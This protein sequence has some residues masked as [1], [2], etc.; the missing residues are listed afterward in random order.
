MNTPLEFF[1]AEVTGRCQLQ[2]VHC[3]ADSGP[4]GT[5]GTMTAT[6]WT[7]AISQ[8][9]QLGA[10]MV[11]FIGGEPTL[12]PALAELIGHALDAGL[13]VEVY[14]NLVHV[15]PALWE[16]FCR[17]GV[18]LAT[19]FYSDDRARHRA[20]TGRDA[21]PRVQANIAEAVRREIP[22]RAGVVDLG[23]GQR[24]DR[25][26]AVLAGLGVTDM[27]VDRMRRLG[28]ASGG[29]R[30]VSELCGRC[31]DGIAAI[32]PDGT[33]TPCPLSRW[34]SA[35]SLREAGLPS[36]IGEVRR[37]SERVI[38]PAAGSRRCGPDHCEPSCNPGCDPGLH[39]PDHCR[40]NASCQPNKP[41]P[42][43]CQPTFKCAPTK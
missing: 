4:T 3:Y 40:P 15:P 21:L 1:W 8:A 43:Q 19:S 24:V 16:V 7:A 30:E 35:G 33:V 42:P 31:G 29:V 20:I 39:K 25:A 23:D 13:Q 36:L 26:Q 37:L 6:D 5:H 32:L 22:L 34:L 12:H 11:Q 10:R 14:S 38:L 41:V 2:C 17:P 27:G 9:A 28:R 18:R